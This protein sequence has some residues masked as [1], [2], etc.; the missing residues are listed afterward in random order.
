LR[1]LTLERPG[2]G[3]PV[4]YRQGPRHEL[5]TSTKGQTMINQQNILRLSLE[6]VTSIDFHNME[7][8]VSDSKS[9]DS[10]TVA[11]FTREQLEREI[12][13]YIRLQRWT[14][15]KE[16]REHSSAFLASLAETCRE[17]LEQIAKDAGE[18]TE[19]TS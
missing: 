8:S 2:S 3:D 5:Q 15:N 10:V 18:A 13:Y 19:A 16:S 9:G 11:G 14:H 4:K 12:A 17:G 1:N 7:M 6:N